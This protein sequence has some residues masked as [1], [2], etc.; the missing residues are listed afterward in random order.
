MAQRQEWQD[1][2]PGAGWKPHRGKTPILLW[3]IVPL[4]RHSWR[5]VPERCEISSGS[6]RRLTRVLCSGLIRMTSAPCITACHTPHLTYLSASLRDRPQ[7]TFHLSARYATPPPLVLVPCPPARPHRSVL[8]KVV[9]LP[10]GKEKCSV[11][12]LVSSSPPVCPSC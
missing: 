5:L 7:R 12:L 1:M 4:A 9:I 10:L 3:H 6:K 11:P 2:R 8:F